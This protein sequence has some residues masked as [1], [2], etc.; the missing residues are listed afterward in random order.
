MYECGNETK[1]CN[2]ELNNVLNEFNKIIQKYMTE[3]SIDIVFDKKNIYI[4]KGSIDITL[5]ILENIEKQLK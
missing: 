2:N 1:K 3:N 4:G 5:I